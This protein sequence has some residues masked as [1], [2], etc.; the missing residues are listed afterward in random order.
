MSLTE[1]ELALTEYG[2]AITEYQP[3][4]TEYGLCWTINYDV[5]VNLVI[6]VWPYVFT[7]II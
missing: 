5:S 1:Y 7:N 3:L 6:C 4:I 2:L